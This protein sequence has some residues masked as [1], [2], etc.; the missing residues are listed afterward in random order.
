[1]EFTN[2][3]LKSIASKGLSGISFLRLASELN[4]MPSELRR[5]RLKNK[6]LD[7]ALRDFEYNAELL[8]AS[9]L[10]EALLNQNGRFFAETQVQLYQYLKDKNGM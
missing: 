4:L 1:M 7:D 9:K 2:E 6:K 10:M 8:F 5:M 3:L